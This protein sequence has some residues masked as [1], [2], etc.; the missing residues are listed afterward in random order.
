MSKPH[1]TTRQLTTAAVIAALY[2][3]L[4]LLLPI[5]QYGGVQLRVAE[6]MTV[7]PFRIKP[8]TA[9]ERWMFTLLADVFDTTTSVK[10]TGP[11]PFTSNSPPAVNEFPL[12][13]MCVVVSPGFNV[14]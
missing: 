8:A 12:S 13:F 5:P 7:L 6:A 10:A 3:G 1:F 14:S 11:R 9:D 2:A 4:T